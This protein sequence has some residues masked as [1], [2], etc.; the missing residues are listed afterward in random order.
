VA[1]ARFETALRI[2][3]NSARA[4]LWSAY[5]NAW[6][7]QGSIAVKNADRAIALSP[8]DP[9]IFT[10]TG[11]AA[12][13]HMA[14]RQYDRA[15]EFALRCMQEN[16]SYITA[17]KV[18]I[19]C[20][21]LSGREAEARNAAHQLLLLDP[22]FTLEKFRRSPASFGPLGELYCGAFARVGVPLLD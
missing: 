18:L 8:Y 3:P 17:H 13:A 2:N 20:L 19:C 12:L 21:V 9:L 6:F 15:I 11:G 16:P 22:S 14:D 4:W 7:N 1:F 5:A 10:F